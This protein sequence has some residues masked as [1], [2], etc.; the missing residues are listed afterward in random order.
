MDVDRPHLA[1]VDH[2]NGRGGDF[3]NRLALA[4]SD[5]EVARNGAGGEQCDREA[6]SLQP[7]RFHAADRRVPG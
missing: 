2:L 1:L 4:S 3:R 7:T 6:R 5:H